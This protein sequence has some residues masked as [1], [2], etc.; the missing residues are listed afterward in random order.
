MKKPKQECAYCGQ[1]DCQHVR[2]TDQHF[3][4]LQARKLT[5]DNGF[6]WPVRSQVLVNDDDFVR[7][8]LCAAMHHPIAV[9][10]GDFKTLSC[11]CGKWRKQISEDLDG[12]VSQ[13]TVDALQDQVRQCQR[14]IQDLRG[15]LEDTIEWLEL[16]GESDVFYDP[17][18]DKL[19]E[20]LNGKAWA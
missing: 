2:G 18:L 13:V 9:R 11:V 20:V 10:R 8:L 19:R 16:E 3:R 15:A 4:E 12:A 5:A 1:I 14:R 17:M 7:D 6:V